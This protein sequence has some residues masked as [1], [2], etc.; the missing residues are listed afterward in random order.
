MNLKLALNVCAVLCGM[1]AATTAVGG[2][3]PAGEWEH[4]TENVVGPQF[5]PGLVWSN[6][7]DRFVF[8]GGT[9]SHHFRGERPYDVQ[10]FDLEQ[11]TW[12]NHL[13]EAAKDRGD[14]TGQVDHPGYATPWF[15]MTD[16]AGLV[17]PSPR[18]MTLWYKYALA[19]WDGNLYMLASGHTL[20][21]DPDARA[22]KNLEPGAGPVPESRSPVLAWASMAADPINRE[23]VLFGG[24]GLATPRADAGTWVYSTE[25]NEWRN[26]FPPELTGEDEEPA[27]PPPRALSPMVYDP[28]TEKIVMFGG[29]GLNQLYADTWVYDCATRTWEE[30]TPEVSPSP[31][32]GHALLH[33]PQAGKI[34]LLGGKGYRLDGHYRTIALPFEMWTYD[35]E[36]NRWDFVRRWDEEPVPPQIPVAAACAAVSKEDDVLW[37]AG[38]TERSRPGGPMNPHSTWRL[39]APNLEGPATDE[40][41]VKYGVEPG[42]V[43]RRTK[44]CDPDW[45]AE[46]LPEPDIDAREQL[47]AELPPNEWV[48][49][50]YEKY[51]GNRNVGGW[52]TVALDTDRDQILH[53]GG[54]H[55]SYFGN[56]VAIYDIPTGR[57]SI[58]YAPMFALE[59]NRGLDGPGPYAFNLAPW[60]NHNYHAYGY[61]ATIGRLVYMKH[62]H[63][64]HLYDPDTKSW[65]FDEKIETPFRID[66]YTTYVVPTPKGMVAWTH[67]AHQTCGI[68]RF[69]DGKEWVQLPLQG[70]IPVTVTDGSAAAYDSKR[71]QLIMITTRNHRDSTVEGQVWTY[72]FATGVCEAKN[73]ANMEAVK[74]ARFAREA[75]YLPEDDLMM[76]GF[77]LNVDGKSVVPFYDPAENNWL[78]AELAGSEFISGRGGVGDSVGLGLVYDP[79][80]NLTWGVLCDLRPGHL[81]AMRL[82]RQRANLTVL[83]AD[84]NQ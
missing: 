75:V 19:P 23:I 42:T 53:L 26:I 65:P 41:N 56:D 40:Q 34:V 1:A 64:A 68:F 14:E 69:E 39:R 73:P 35:V 20:R 15:A 10:T 24:C 28:A 8:F 27:Q 16:R 66:K 3:P 52:S 70:T 74:V 45:Y 54:G 9:V 12:F 83:E 4:V 32:F 33:F 46:G 21:Y 25:R 7:L 17:A 59:Y 6:Q 48:A 80:R 44:S 63:R 81:R 55:A 47:L 77:I 57:W 43:T 79:K 18:R 72:D 62:Q 22:W 31:R 29:D 30:R 78:V 60:G 38:G 61:D 50:E 82:D 37:V 13:P 84:D 51:P 5:S 2:E 49:M 58:S 76:V 71:D 11:N 67:V 36:A